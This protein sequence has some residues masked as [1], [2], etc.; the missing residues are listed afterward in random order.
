MVRTID[1]LVTRFHKMRAR[2]AGIEVD[3]GPDLSWK[4]QLHNRIACLSKVAQLIDARDYLEIG[5]DSGIVLKS[6]ACPNKVGVDPGNGGT[7]RTTSDKFFAS[8]TQKF[9]LVFID[10]LHEY[11]Q[12]KRDI[13][14]ALNALRPGGAILVHDC[15]PLSYQAQ[16]VPSIAGHGDWN[17]DVW[18]AI[19]QFKQHPGVDTRVITVDHGVGLLLP[20]PNTDL[21]DFGAGDFAKR[22]YRFYL[23]HWRAFGL[24]DYEEIEGFVTGVSG[25]RQP[26][27]KS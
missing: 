12:V 13:E 9:D 2:R 5:C 7:I 24:I 19:A 27:A 21:K 15:L 16:T 23:D 22:D 26:P 11:A 8:N 20:R 25:N 3:G 14:N 18:K 17:G 6:L 1:K 4:E 10:G